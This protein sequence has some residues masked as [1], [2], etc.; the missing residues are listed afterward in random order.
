MIGMPTAN[1]WQILWLQ[2]IDSVN[3]ELRGFE[4]KS[5][6]AEVLL[7]SR[8]CVILFTETINATKLL[9]GWNITQN[10][11]H[12]YFPINQDVDTNKR[13]IVGQCL[14]GPNV[15]DIPNTGEYHLLF[16]RNIS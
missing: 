11:L 2:F 14:A 8:Q 4:E 7:D 6:V 3:Q 9:S 16:D 15:R 5:W 1:E 10:P 12:W 13:Y